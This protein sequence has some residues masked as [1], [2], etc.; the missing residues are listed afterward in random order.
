M[1]K[2]DFLKLIEYIPP[3]FEFREMDFDNLLRNDSIQRK[4]LH[5]YNS[6]F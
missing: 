6:V 5:I 3:V 4:Y 2:A 1:I